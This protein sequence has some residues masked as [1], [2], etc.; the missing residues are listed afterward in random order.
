MIQALIIAAFVVVYLH[1][2]LVGASGPD[3]LAPGLGAAVTVGGLGVI[4]AFAS[5][6]IMALARVID[7]TGSHRAIRRAERWVVRGRVLGTVLFAWG[8]LGLGHLR[9]VRE[10]MGNLVVVDELLALSP[11]LGLH[12]GLWWSIYPIERRLREALVL[13]S[14]DAGRPIPGLVSRRRFVVSSVRNHLLLAA[15]PLTLL[16]G[17][18]ELIGWVESERPGWISLVPAPSVTINAVTFA[19]IAALFATAPL[20]LRRVWETQRLGPGAL[21]EHLLEMCARH[22]V[23]VSDVLVW[24]TD[25]LSVNAAV[26]G[27]LGRIRYILM[28]DGLLEQLGREEV[29]A[30][31]AH[32]IAHARHHHIPWLAT[33]VL[34]TVLSLTTLGGWVVEWTL[35]T[36]ALDAAP[37]MIAAGAG[38]VVGLLGF[39]YISRRF[40]WQADAFAAQ[41]LSGH[42]VGHRA[43]GSQAVTIHPDAAQSMARALGSV[44]RLNGIP[45]HRGSWRHGS[46]AERQRRLADLVGQPA[47]RLAIDH[48]VVWLKIACLLVAMMAAAMIALEVTG[49]LGAS[50]LGERSGMM[51][52]SP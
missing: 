19:G 42:R 50:P 51:G 37:G 30:V 2:A 47:D 38:L 16:L 13:G 8:V 32:E 14:L 43:T 26:M 44:A 49:T 17:W 28:T 9:W 52:A 10:V 40:E 15:V 33:G 6:R 12:V 25:G 5:L 4:W 46:I 21:R 45:S 7:T 31:A 39:G 35:G 20:I 1:D 18:V 34:G 24:R 48:T 11:L 22:G 23:R 29:E 3:N 36:D 27:V 41:H